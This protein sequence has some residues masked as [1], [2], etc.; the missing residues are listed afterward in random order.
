[1]WSFYFKILPENQNYKFFFSVFC[2]VGFDPRACVCINVAG[3]A[4]RA[5]EISFEQLLFLKTSR[6]PA[7][8]VPNSHVPSGR[9]YGPRGGLL[10][11]LH[12]EHTSLVVFWGVISS[13][14][15]SVLRGF[16]AL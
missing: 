12:T 3:G 5:N 10:N 15:T 13:S 4:S 2:S 14:C 11:K 8:K 6:L 16:T 7:F 9:P 1:M